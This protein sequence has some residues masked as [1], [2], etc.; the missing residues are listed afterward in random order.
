VANVRRNILSSLHTPSGCEKPL[1]A[2]FYMSCESGAAVEGACCG[3]RLLMAELQR[4]GAAP[5]LGGQSEGAP[6]TR[7]G[8]SPCAGGLPRTGGYKAW[9]AR[10]ESLTQVSRAGHSCIKVKHRR[11]LKWTK[12]QRL[13][14][15]PPG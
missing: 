8:S 10:R 9:P 7:L 4:L 1:K 3:S 13:G 2:L 15:P 11:H 6:A 12:T 14:K 5:G